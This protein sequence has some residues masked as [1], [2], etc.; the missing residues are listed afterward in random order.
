[1]GRRSV[2]MLKILRGYKTHKRL[3]I[4]QIVKRFYVKNGFYTE[5][6]ITVPQS[7]VPSPNH[8]YFSKLG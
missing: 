4:K 1:M 8:K 2:V 7:D 3:I 5:G 6:G